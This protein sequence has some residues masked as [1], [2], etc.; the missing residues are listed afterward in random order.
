MVEGTTVNGNLGT[1]VLVGIDLGHVRCLHRP[2]GVVG[3]WKDF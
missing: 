2:V 3:V 1:I